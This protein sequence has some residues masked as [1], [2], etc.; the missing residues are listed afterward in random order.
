MITTTYPTR[1]YFGEFIKSS[2]FKSPEMQHIVQGGKI[3]VEGRTYKVVNERYVN[4]TAQE[5]SLSER[6]SAY[7]LEIGNVAED[8]NDIR[9]LYQDAEFPLKSKIL[10]EILTK[11]NPEKAHSM[12]STFDWKD[13]TVFELIQL[14]NKCPF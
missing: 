14:M 6:L 12:N 5:W 13:L 2:S 9:E 7:M 10:N 11:E 8:L 1:K 3:K 4:V